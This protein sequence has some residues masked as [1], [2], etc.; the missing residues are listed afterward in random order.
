MGCTYLPPGRKETPQTLI[1]QADAA[2]YRSKQLGRNRTTLYKGGLL[3]RGLLHRS[4]E[5]SRRT[6]VLAESSI[7]G[8]E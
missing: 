2:L 7:P 1:S 5:E 8:L 6:R 3:Y 4:L